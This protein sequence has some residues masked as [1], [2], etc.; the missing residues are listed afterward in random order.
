MAKT[1]PCRFFAMYL[2]QRVAADARQT[3]P[4]YGRVSWGGGALST[5]HCPLSS[6]RARSMAER[7]DSG[8]W[9]CF[10]L[11]GP[12]RGKPQ[13]TWPL[14]PLVPWSLGPLLLWSSGPLFP[15]SPGPLVPWP[16]GPLLPCSLPAPLV[17][18]SPGPLGSPGCLVPWSPGPVV[19]W[20][21]WSLDPLVFWS[22]A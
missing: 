3:W 6:A 16:L 5:V 17:V 10:V 22:P 4:S 21:P 9:T 13:P 19:P 14:G 18:W 11:L 1:A 20:S 2:R 15:W 12:T 7:V 8:Q